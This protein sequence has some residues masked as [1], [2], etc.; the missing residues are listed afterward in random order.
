MDVPGRQDLSRRRGRLGACRPV[1]D[2]A[3]RRQI[4]MRMAEL[5]KGDAAGIDADADAEFAGV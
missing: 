3:D 2:G 1:D 4:A 5:T